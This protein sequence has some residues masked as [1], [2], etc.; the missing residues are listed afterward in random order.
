[1]NYNGYTKKKENNNNNCMLFYAMSQK[2][3][4]PFLSAVYIFM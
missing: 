1:M 4:W 2:D 3:K